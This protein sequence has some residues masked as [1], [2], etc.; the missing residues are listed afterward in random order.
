MAATV[1][2]EPIIGE[3]V[4][5]PDRTMIRALP[6]PHRLQGMIGEH[7]SART[8]DGGEFRDIHP[9]SPGDRLRRID[10]KATARRG[11]SAGDLYVR[12]TNAL[13][14][15][16]VLIVMDSRDDVGEQIAEWSRNAALHKGLSSL[17]VAREAATSIASAYIASGDRVGFQ[18]LSSRQ[19]MIQHAGG[20][21][22]LWRLLRAIEVTAPSST[23]FRH[24]RPPI[25]PTGALV[26]LLSSLLDDQSVNLALSWL[27][28][29]HRVIAVDV[30]PP[31]L[32][33]RTSRHERMAHRMVLM[34]RDDRIRLLRVRGVEVLHWSGEHDGP[35]LAARLQLLSRSPRQ[36]GSA[37]ARR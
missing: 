16:T 35:S 13:A 37:G 23:P 20:G 17:D 25:V 28:T 18:D 12:R 9:F 33:E 29:G 19:R 31:P 2:T 4:V 14:D 6:L 8:G 34:E 26:Y 15:A 27:G 30:L 21:R 1:P 24:Q 22:H 32:F 3:L 11:Q 10:W 7:Q 5:A 36:L